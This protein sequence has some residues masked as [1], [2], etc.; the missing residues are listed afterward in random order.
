MNGV[1]PDKAIDLLENVFADTLWNGE[2]SFKLKDIQR[3][4]EILKERQNE[5][6]EVLLWV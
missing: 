6:E 1:F 4:T 5:L 2:N 3:V